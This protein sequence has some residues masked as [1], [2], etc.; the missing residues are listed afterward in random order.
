MKIFTLLILSTARVDEEAVQWLRLHGSHTEDSRCA[1]STCIK[2][3]TIACNSSFRLFS[4]QFQTL[5][6]LQVSVHPEAETQALYL[7]QRNYW[8]LMCAGMNVVV[9]QRGSHSQVVQVVVN[10]HA[11]HNIHSHISNNNLTQRVKK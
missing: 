7:S 9:L 1:C 2:Q 4:T 3:K 6:D 8:Q 5:W 11:N 10:T